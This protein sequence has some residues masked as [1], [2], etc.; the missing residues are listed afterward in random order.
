M[1]KLLPGAGVGHVTIPDQAPANQ[2]R[3]ARLA[4]RAEAVGDL[5]DHAKAAR[6]ASAL[7]HP[8]S[9]HS[10]LCATGRGADH[11]TAGALGG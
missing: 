2:P 5:L 3:A 6:T 8:V 1:R 11:D 9:Q 7:S 10:H 4:H